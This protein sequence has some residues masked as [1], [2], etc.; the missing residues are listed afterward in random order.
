MN[1][2]LETIPPFID[3]VDNACA[4]STRVS[5]P[6]PARIE[7]CYATL[8]QIDAKAKEKGELFGYSP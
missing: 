4:M 5:W 3:Q 1:A 6:E 8:G 2:L 7:T